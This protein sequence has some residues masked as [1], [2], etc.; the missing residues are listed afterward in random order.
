MREI[1]Y[2]FQ[3]VPRPSEYRHFPCSTAIKN[4]PRVEDG[5]HLLAIG[6]FGNSDLRRSQG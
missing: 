3:P 6:A 2:L 5:A 4:L 1:E